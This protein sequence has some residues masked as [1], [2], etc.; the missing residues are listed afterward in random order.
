MRLQHVSF[1]AEFHHLSAQKIALGQLQCAD[2]ALQCQVGKNRQQDKQI[3]CLGYSHVT[4][5]VAS[6]TQTMTMSN[7][8]VSSRAQLDEQLH[9]S[10]QEAWA[11]NPCAFKPGCL[12]SHYWLHTPDRKI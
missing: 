7:L 12:M 11:N 10:T 4:A 5:S 1:D 2:H 6:L 3:C 9:D 8:D